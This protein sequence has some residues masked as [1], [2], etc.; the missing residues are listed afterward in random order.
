MFA[1]SLGEDVVEKKEEVTVIFTQKLYDLVT[2]IKH[3][4]FNLMN[5]FFVSL[6][7]LA[8]LMIFHWRFE[9]H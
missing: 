6:F 5:S 9:G 1:S 7:L 8:H 3:A 4:A 2:S